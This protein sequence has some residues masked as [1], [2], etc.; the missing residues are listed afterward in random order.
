MILYL[1][2][3][4]ADYWLIW[5]GFSV[6]FTLVAMLFI[7]S[8]YPRA[9]IYIKLLHDRSETTGVYNRSTRTYSFADETGKIHTA[10]ARTIPDANW[11][12]LK[13]GQSIPIIYN[14][15]YPQ[16]FVARWEAKGIR[17]SFAIFSCAV[18]VILLAI[19]VTLL[20]TYKYLSLSRKVGYL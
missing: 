20:S 2:E 18:G 12:K 11:S 13:D 4:K 19:L 17:L 6:L 15:I 10:T 1:K 5:I 8:T 3:T 7:H 14:K 16:F 9:S